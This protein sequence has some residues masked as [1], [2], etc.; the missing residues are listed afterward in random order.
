MDLM[1][2]FVMEELKLLENGKEITRSDAEKYIE[3]NSL[4]ISTSAKF[5]FGQL[6]ATS[7]YN[8]D[9]SKG[10]WSVRYDDVELY[11]SQDASEADMPMKDRWF[12]RCVAFIKIGNFEG[13]F[14]QSYSFLHFFQSYKAQVH[15]IPIFVWW[16]E[17]K[18]RSRQN[19]LRGDVIHVRI[20]PIESVKSRVCMVKDWSYKLV[21]QAGDTEQGQW[22]RERFLLNDSFMYF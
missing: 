14:L 1:I 22:K 3:N 17:N 20:V 8:F 15:E 16:P 5:H 10:A 18:A 9:R 6:R 7:K 2:G 12:G 4:R 13:V 11:T 21:H 19:R